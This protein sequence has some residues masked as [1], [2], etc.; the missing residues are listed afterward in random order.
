MAKIISLSPIVIFDDLKQQELGGY[1]K[2][3]HP[4]HNFELATIE[5]LQDIVTKFGI[6]CSA[7]DPIPAKL[8][9]SI[10]DICLPVWLEIVNLSLSTGNMD[11]LKSAV[12]TPILKQMDDMVDIE[13]YK[14]YRPVS[15][16]TFVSKLIERCVADRLNKHM[17]DNNLECDEQYGYKKGHSTELLLMNIVDKVLRGFDDNYASVLLLLDLSAAFDTVDHDLLLLILSRDIGIRGVAY[18]W[19]ESFI[20]GRMVQVKI[21]SSFS[22]PEPLDY[23]VAQGSVLGPPLF[24]IYIRSFYPHVHVSTPFDMEGYADDNQLLKKFIV[25]FQMEI[26]GFS[27]N[28]CLKSVS[29]WMNKFCLK[30]NKDKT[31]ILVFAH[32]LIMKYIKIHGIFVDGEC[33]RFVDCAKNLGIWLDE[34][35][36]FRNKSR[37]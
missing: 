9:S 4:E 1:Y 27:I 22:D 25:S 12:I 21:N 10:V 33:V 6:K 15:N 2:I 36:N 29:E 8:L 17:V 19:F 3:L 11:C 34:C 32:P 18:K 14:N 16:L 7:V 20:K 31:K 13:I 5:E 30:L 28:E 26:L 35:L 24:G 37:K 23:G